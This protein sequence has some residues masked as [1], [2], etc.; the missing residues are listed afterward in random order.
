MGSVGQGGSVGQRENPSRSSAWRC[1]AGLSVVLKIRVSVV[2]FRPWPPPP[3]FE[4]QRVSGITRALSARA[5]GGNRPTIGLPE[6]GSVRRVHD[7]VR[8]AIWRT[9]NL[10]LW[11]PRGVGRVDAG[12]PLPEVPAWGGLGWSPWPPPWPDPARPSRRGGSAFGTHERGYLNHH[13]TQQTCGPGTEL[14]VGGDA[15]VSDG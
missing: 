8:A 11:D 4:T 2:R 15:Q 7:A 14:S 3:I 1:R 13:R 9:G 12:P 10:E 5:G 6:I